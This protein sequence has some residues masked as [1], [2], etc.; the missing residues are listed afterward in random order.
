MGA[1]RALSTPRGG[2]NNP[3]GE[4]AERVAREPKSVAEAYR[5]TYRTLLRFSNVEEVTQLAPVWQRLANCLKSEQHTVLTQEF[6][7]VC[8]A[9]GLSTEYYVPVVT[10]ALKQMVV[11]FQFVGFGSDDLTSG[12]QPF[13]VAYAG[14]ANHYQVLAAADVSNQLAQGEHA[15]SLTDYK[16]IKDKENIRRW[17]MLTIF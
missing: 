1:I 2:G 17:D 15:A 11:G 7:K 13:L 4:D 6:Q 5:E 3:G 16:A 10:T 9:R 14:R 8:M 12:C